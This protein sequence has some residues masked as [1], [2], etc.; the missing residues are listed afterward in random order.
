[1]NSKGIG[2]I[3]FFKNGLKMFCSKKY[4]D[5]LNVN[6]INNEVCAAVARCFPNILDIMVLENILSSD[7]MARPPLWP[8]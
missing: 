8:N 7:K 2:Y 6:R 3:L 4:K 5:N 1:M